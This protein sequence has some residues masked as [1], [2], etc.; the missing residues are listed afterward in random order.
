[1]FAVAQIKKLRGRAQLSLHAI[2]PM[3][4]LEYSQAL[5]RAG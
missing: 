2:K 5:Y 1:M 4:Q 3:S